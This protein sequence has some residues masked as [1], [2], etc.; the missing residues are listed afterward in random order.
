MRKKEPW[1]KKAENML[2]CV[3]VLDN[4]PLYAENFDIFY[5]PFQEPY[6]KDIVKQLQFIM[7][8]PSNTKHKFVLAG[9]RAGK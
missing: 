6:R 7:R 8:V 2:E 9:H 1:M 5:T 4:G 3:A